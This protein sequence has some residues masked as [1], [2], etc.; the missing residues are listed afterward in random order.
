MNCVVQS[1]ITKALPGV[2]EI[3]P[4]SEFFIPN[5]I[6]FVFATNSF[7]RGRELRSSHRRLRQYRFDIE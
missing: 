4:T 1:A 7:E 2:G 5:S 3:I 6:M